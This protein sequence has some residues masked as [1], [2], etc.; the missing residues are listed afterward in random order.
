MD[1]GCR[2]GQRFQGIVFHLCLAPGVSV[3][4]GERAVH[5]DACP[6]V[7]SSLLLLKYDC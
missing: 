2:H 1:E 3:I 7:S 4:I 6:N 5:N